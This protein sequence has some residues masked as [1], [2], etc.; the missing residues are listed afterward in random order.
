MPLLLPFPICILEKWNA[1]KQENKEQLLFPL[2]ESHSP[3]TNSISEGGGGRLGFDDLRLYSAC[4]CQWDVY[5]CETMTIF[6]Y[7]INVKAF[8]YIK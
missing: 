6:M 5:I 8:K 7:M 3:S 2:P 4:N 1:F